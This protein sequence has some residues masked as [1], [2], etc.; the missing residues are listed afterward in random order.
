MISANDLLACCSDCGYG[1]SG[2]YLPSAWH[3]LTTTGVVTGGNYNDSTTRSWCQKYSLPNCDHHEG[4]QYQLCSA[5]PEYPTPTCTQQCDATTLYSTPYDKDH[6]VFASAYSIAPDVT[7]IATEI[8]TNGPV[9]AAFTV[10]EDFLTYKSGVY[11]HQTGGV[12]GGHAIKIIGWGEEAGVP[13]WL[14]VNSW[15]ADWGDK[16]TFKILKGK[17]ECGIE[18]QVIAGKYKASL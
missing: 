13:Y 18:D 5:R 6:H 1:C 3:Y 7:A 8:Y 4:G 10:Y 2:G 11:S 9:E 14:V 12:D 16:G 17:D 15:N